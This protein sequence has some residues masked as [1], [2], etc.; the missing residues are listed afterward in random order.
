MPR[1]STQ[2]I[3]EAHLV[4][5]HVICDFVEMELSDPQW[6]RD[7]PG[8]ASFSPLRTGRADLGWEVSATI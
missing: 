3:Q 2:R 8:V 4:I 5:E 6:T 1:E 7:E